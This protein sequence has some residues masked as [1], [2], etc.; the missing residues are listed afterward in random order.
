MK[1]W[2]SIIMSWYSLMRVLS[3]V[4]ENGMHSSKNWKSVRPPQ[5][6]LCVGNT[7]VN[8]LFQFLQIFFNLL[9]VATGRISPHA[10]I[11]FSLCVC[12][13]IVF[14]WLTVAVM[15]WS[16]YPLYSFSMLAAL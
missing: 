3:S 11:L 5:N 4:S 14:N 1:Q 10:I 9:F 2:F 8:G 12:Q 7:A 15:R 6:N 16:M 13:L